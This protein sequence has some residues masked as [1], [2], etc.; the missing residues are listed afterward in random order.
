MAKRV[1]FSFDFSEDLWRASVVRNRW[2]SDPSMAEGGLWSPEFTEG[3][4]PHRAR[5]EQ[6]VDQQVEAPRLDIHFDHVAG[7]NEGQWPA[8][9]RLR[10]DVQHTGP[11]RCAAHPRI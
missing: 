6:F 2:I 7:P 5:L 8:D 1:F 4:P 11:V 3:P 10:R 9:R